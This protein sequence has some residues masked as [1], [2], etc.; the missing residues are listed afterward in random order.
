MKDV[1]IEH[2]GV[3]KGTPCI[4]SDECHEEAEADQH[5]HVDILVSRVTLRVE[6][7]TKGD[8]LISGEDP[9]K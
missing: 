6:G 2:E 8:E 3:G 4:A 9:K 5:H 7:I 1:C